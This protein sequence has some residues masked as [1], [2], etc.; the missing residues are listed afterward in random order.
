MASLIS[1]TTELTDYFNCSRQ[2]HVAFANIVKG[3]NW[4]LLHLTLAYEFEI[5]NFIS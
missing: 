4:K 5:I 3:G 2:F 1:G